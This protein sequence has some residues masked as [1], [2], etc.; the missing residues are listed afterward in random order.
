MRYLTN[1]HEFLKVHSLIHFSMGFTFHAKKLEVSLSNYH[2]RFHWHGLYTWIFVESIAICY[3][4]LSFVGHVIKSYNWRWHCEV[5]SSI[6]RTTNNENF[7]VVS[8]CHVVEG[9]K[10]INKGSKTTINSWK[11]INN[12]S[13]TLTSKKR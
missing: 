7:F 11:D 1:I 10:W 2:L 8:W 3:C 6:Y 4:H 9:R 5:A 13:K 12:K